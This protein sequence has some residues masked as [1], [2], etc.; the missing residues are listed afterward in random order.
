M[1]IATV[2]TRDILTCSQNDTLEG[3]ARAMFEHH[4]GILP[5]TDEEG[6]AVGV[7]TDRDICRAAYIEGQAL[8]EIPV[9]AAMSTT[10]V[11]ASPSASLDDVAELM[12]SCQIRRVLVV[13]DE[14]RAIGI[15][16]LADLAR[17]FARDQPGDG[18]SADGVARAL[19]AI[20]Q[21]SSEPSA[22][23]RVASEGGALLG[24]M[25]ARAEASRPPVKGPYHVRSIDGDWEVFDRE[26]RRVSE[27]Q[28]TQSD[29]VIRAK[30]LA[31]REGSAQ[32]IVH[33]VDGSIASEFF[34]QREERAPLALDDA[35]PSVAATRPAHAEPESRRGA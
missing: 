25:I 17:P 26:G 34:Y 19:A 24:A 18:M 35:I 11:A 7:I 23:E 22:I 33:R 5:V 2:M 6:R 30:E 20:V 15:V 8:T 28:R 10:L 4:C 14:Q 13:D 32:V 1:D 12:Q 21:P 27:R 31:Y 3:A 29:A 16:S 9:W